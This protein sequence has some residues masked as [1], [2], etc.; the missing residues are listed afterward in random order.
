[1]KNIVRFVI[2]LAQICIVIVWAAMVTC[3]LVATYYH[4]GGIWGMFLALCTG[5]LVV[6]AVAVVV[7]SFVSVEEWL[8][9]DK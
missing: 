3:I 8:E 7:A 1:M 6:S 4:F 2:L 9:E 5:L